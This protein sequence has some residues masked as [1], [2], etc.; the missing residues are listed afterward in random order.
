M[1]K[2][3]FMAALMVAMTS[4]AYAQ[5]VPTCCGGDL[6]G[7]LDFFPH[8]QTATDTN[9]YIVWGQNGAAVDVKGTDA[10]LEGDAWLILGLGF[11]GPTVT[12]DITSGAAPGCACSHSGT[13]DASFTVSNST[14]VIVIQK[15]YQG[16]DVFPASSELQISSSAA[17]QVYQYKGSD[18]CAD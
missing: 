10:C 16:A 8:F 14:A 13:Y 18:A 9:G 11:P 2:I 4:M 3:L 7:S 15:Y 1:K 17:I 6:D 5:N 12:Y